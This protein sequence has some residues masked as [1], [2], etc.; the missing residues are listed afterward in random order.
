MSRTPPSDSQ[1]AVRTGPGY[2]L[3]GLP[4]AFVA[5]PLYVHLPNV[6][7]SRYGLPL[8]T[9][10]G[11]LLLARLFDAV[12]DPWLGR[13]GDRLFARSPRHVLAAGALA[14]VLLVLGMA[15]LFFSTVGEPGPPAGAA[16]HAHA[17]LPGLQPAGHHPPGLGRPARR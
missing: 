2:G 14:A 1:P 12:T 9:L 16:G 11:V 13:L 8:P 10:G 17:D 6:Y 4:L 7:A 5:L 15:L 3:L